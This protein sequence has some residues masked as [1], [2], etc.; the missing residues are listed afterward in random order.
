M[1]N[2]NYTNT[3]TTT[4]GDKLKQKLSD[5]IGHIQSGD[6]DYFAITSLEGKLF[7]VCGKHATEL[8]SCNVLIDKGNGLEVARAYNSNATATIPPFTLI[9]KK[10][11]RLIMNDNDHI[12]AF[13][14]KDIAPTA[15]TLF[16]HAKTDIVHTFIAASSSSS[17]V[18]VFKAMSIDC[19]SDD[20]IL[21]CMNSIFASVAAQHGK[22]VV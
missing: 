11:K 5:W 22:E 16:V 20:P 14:V 17:Q 18:E 8:V 13:G 7:Y 1:T 10:D 9:V 6:A 12:V 2:L 3:S 15:K 21:H 4:S 19:G